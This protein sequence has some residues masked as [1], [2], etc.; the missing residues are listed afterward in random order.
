MSKPMVLL[1]ARNQLITEPY[2]CAECGAQTPVATFN[3]TYEYGVLK[4]RG[5]HD[6]F[7]Q[8]LIREHNLVPYMRKGREDLSCMTLFYK[9]PGH[10]TKLTYGHFCRMRC[11]V[12]FGNAVLDRVQ[13]VEEHEF[14]DEPDLDPVWADAD[15]LA[16]AGFGTDEDY[17]G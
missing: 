15:A 3:E 12:S 17:G 6:E 10:Y 13:Q 9:V 5:S 4:I 8:E 1:V 2:C 14:D 11:A 7:Y 16:S